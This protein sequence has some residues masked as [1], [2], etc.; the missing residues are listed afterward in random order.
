MLNVEKTGNCTFIEQLVSKLTAICSLQSRRLRNQIE[1]PVMDELSVKF[2]IVLTVSVIIYG[3]LLSLNDFGSLLDD[4]RSH[5]LGLVYLYTVRIF[6]G[7]N[8]SVFLWRVLLVLAYK[9]FE[10]CSDKQLPHCTVIVPAYNEGKGVLTTLKSVVESIYPAD[11]MQIIAIDDGSDDDTFEW[12]KTAC[13]LMPGRIE[14]IRFEKNRGKREAL[15]E[16][17]IRSR[18][19]IIVTIDS[20]SVIEPQ[21]LRRLVSPFAADKSIGAVA[22]NV[23]V[24]NYDEGLI[25][26]MLDVIFAYSF[27]FLRA[28]QS[29]VNTVFCTPGALSAYRKEVVMKNLNAWLNQTFLGTKAN[30]GEDRALTN[31]II[32]DGWN[33]KFQSNAVVYTMVPTTYGK[34]CKMFLRWA[35]SNVRETLAMAAF[36]FKKFRRGSMSGARVNF[37]MSCINIV[38]P[39]AIAS[40][41]IGFIFLRPQIY[42]SQLMLGVVISSTAPAVFYALRKKNSDSLWA[43]AYGLFWFAGLWWITPWAIA[44]CR[45]G[46]WLT[47]QLPTERPLTPGRR[48]L[49]VPAGLGTAA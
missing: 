30:I 38:V 46:N 33:V 23:R 14:S 49:S 39:Q 43:Y 31:M 44:T 5:K 4:I 29:M 18:G 42:L 6:L 3:S 48:I 28:S 32:N 35:R 40:L 10:S 19:R 11:K 36:I 22:G 13:R 8:L 1:L 25:P 45:N 20:D 47:R 37:I 41:I 12:I 26:K 9:P 17:I 7:L 34:L 24:L 15:F 21:T 2:I 27:D 16:G